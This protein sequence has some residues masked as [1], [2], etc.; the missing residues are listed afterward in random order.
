[1]VNA[2]SGFW[3]QLL[4]HVAGWGWPFRSRQATGRPRPALGGSDGLYTPPRY[5]IPLLIFKGNGA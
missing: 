2:A 4:T 1:V 5:D 3:A